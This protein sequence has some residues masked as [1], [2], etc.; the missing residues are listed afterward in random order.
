VY[1]LSS[2][3]IW[4]KEKRR[5]LEP[6]SASKGV[7]KKIFARE[8]ALI[9][10]KERTPKAIKKRKG[11]SIEIRGK[12]GRKRSP[13][14]EIT[15]LLRWN[16]PEAEAYLGKNTEKDEIQQKNWK[17]FSGKDRNGFAAGLRGKKRERGETILAERKWDERRN[18]QHH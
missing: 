12:F 6:W 2:L 18:P 8:K 5:V 17:N 4:G 9:F 16:S 7:K 15:Q 14:G 1:P 13:G 10:E 3:P 11:S